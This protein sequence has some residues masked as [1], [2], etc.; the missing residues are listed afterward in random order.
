MALPTLSQIQG[1]DTDHLTTAADHWAGTADRWETAFTQAWQEAHTVSWEGHGANA[2][3][4]RVSADKTTVAGHAELLRQAAGIARQGASD[5]GAAQ[6]KVLYAV[7]DATNAGFRVDDDLS[8]IDKRISHNAGQRAGRR[9]QAQRFAGD[10]RS[11]A[12]ELS[13][14]DNEVATNITNAAGGIGTT[15]FG[16]GVEGKIQAVG[17][18]FKEADP[19][20]PPPP[21]IPTT[22]DRERGLAGRVVEGAI[23]GGILGTP[24]GGV[25]GVPPE[26]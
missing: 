8:V 17:N 26:P 19:K 6:R 13:T 22:E 16:D 5:I 24:E 21:N 10:I 4:E 14:L 1:W 25:G 9:A 11:A 3:R 18:G 12:A 7:Q 23:I 15:T 2:L 20:Q